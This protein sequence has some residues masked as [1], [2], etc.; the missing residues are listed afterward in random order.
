MVPSRPHVAPPALH[1]QI[2]LGSPPAQETLF[3]PSGVLTAS[4]CPSGEKNGYRATDW[5]DF[6]GVH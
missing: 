3:S 2:V 1:S 6:K 5:Y 4:D